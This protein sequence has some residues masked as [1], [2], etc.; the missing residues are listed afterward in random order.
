MPAHRSGEDD[1]FQIAALLDE[2]FNGIAVRDANNILLDDGP[3]VEDLGD[4]MAGSADQ[5]DAASER[6]MVRSGPN[7]CRQK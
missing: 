6:L 1:L 2:V 5:L 3:V 4:V 7:E